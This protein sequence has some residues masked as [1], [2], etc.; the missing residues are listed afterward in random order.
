[1]PKL[2]FK[3]YE[4]EPRSGKLIENKAGPSFKKGKKMIGKL[5]LGGGVDSGTINVQVCFK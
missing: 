2:A 4:I 3:F 5:F 1:M